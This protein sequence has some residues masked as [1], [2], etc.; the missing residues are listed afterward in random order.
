MF[1]FDFEYSTNL[2]LFPFGRC[3]TIDFSLRVSIVTYTP[4]MAATCFASGLS[5]YQLD[6]ETFQEVE[7]FSQIPTLFSELE[8]QGVETHV[9]WSKEFEH[10]SYVHSKV[11]DKSTKNHYAPSGGSKSITPQKHAFD[12]DISINSEFPEYDLADYF[13][14]QGHRFKHMFSRF[15]S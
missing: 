4:G 13:Y 5:A 14:T 10:L 1:L 3:T 7:E 2:I 11:F 9:L 8:E 6:R 12:K 15:A